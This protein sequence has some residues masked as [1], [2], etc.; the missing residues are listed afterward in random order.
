MI[1]TLK[2]K[3]LAF[4]SLVSTGVLGFAVTAKMAVDADVASSSAAVTAA[5]ADNVKGAI[6]ANIG[7]L[8][9]IGALLLVIFLVWRMAKRFSK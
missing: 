5:L 2:S 7:T 6:T 9:T 1:K 3:A 4:A 8:V